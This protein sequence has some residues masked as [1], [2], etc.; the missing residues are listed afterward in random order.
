MLLHLTALSL[1]V[2]DLQLYI[3]NYTLQVR[4]LNEHDE[5]SSHS[6]LEMPRQG[7]CW[8]V[9]L[10]CHLWAEGGAGGFLSSRSGPPSGDL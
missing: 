9:C 8:N 5:P 1:L 3:D 4:L 6:H 2:T 10:P 7:P